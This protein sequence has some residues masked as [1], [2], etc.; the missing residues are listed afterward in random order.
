M[1]PRIP[2][3]LGQDIQRKFSGE[4]FAAKRL[5]LLKRARQIAKEHIEGKQKKY[6]IQHG[7]KAKPHD[8]SIGQQVL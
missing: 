8:F 4:L 6:K 5:Q 3:I 2:S 1:K 7:K